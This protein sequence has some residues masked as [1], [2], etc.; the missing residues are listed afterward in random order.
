H[1]QQQQQQQQPQQ[2]LNHQQQQAAQYHYGQP[3]QYHYGQQ[4]QQAAAAAAVAFQ[5]THTAHRYPSQ[6]NIFGQLPGISNFITSTNQS[7]SG[8]Q[9]STPQQQQQTQQQH[10]QGVVGGH[11]NQQQ[12][13]FQQTGN[14]KS[15]MIGN[16][17]GLSSVIQATQ[18]VDPV[19]QQ[20]QQ[21]QQHQ[22]QFQQSSTHGVSVSGQPHYTTT[23]GVPSGQYQTISAAIQSQPQQQL[24]VHQGD[25]SSVGTIGMP[26]STSS[27]VA[28][29]GTTATGA[30]PAKVRKQRVVNLDKLKR[31][32]RCTAS[33]CRKSYK[34]KKGLIKHAASAHPG[35]DIP[36][37]KSAPTGVAKKHAAAAAA[38]GGG[39]GGAYHL[40]KAHVAGTAPVPVPAPVAVPIPQPPP[41]QQPTAPATTTKSRRGAATATATTATAQPVANNFAAQFGTNLGLGGVGLLGSVGG[42][43]NQVSTVGATTAGALAGDESKPFV[44]PHPG[45]GKA[46]KNRNGL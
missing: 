12:Q 26:G 11:Q 17:M 35:V 31:P 1:H 45:C 18:M 34:K 25:G 43:Q 37:V 14:L 30:T 10:V 3:A 9:Q 36:I 16:N 39:G 24:L 40:Q 21:Q 32:F 22:Q 2:H 13:M 46:Y 5:N 27:A 44:C 38:A 20:Q 28:V 4:Q 15:N 23:H 19:H 6:Q 33:G 41:P 8:S 29:A 42:G 7:L